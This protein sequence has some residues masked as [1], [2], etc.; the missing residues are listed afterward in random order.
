MF[1]ANLTTLDQ[2]NQTAAPPLV[3]LGADPGERYPFFATTLPAYPQIVA[4]VNAVVAAHT[5]A[6]GP[7]AAPQ[8]DLCDNAAGNWAP[9]GCEAVGECLPVPRSNVTRCLWYH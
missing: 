1:V 2:R 6:M 7:W 5:A 8:L 9:P 3:Y 4:S